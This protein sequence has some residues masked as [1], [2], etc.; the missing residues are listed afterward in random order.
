MS[1]D[2]SESYT[3]YPKSS[4]A[5]RRSA[6]LSTSAPLQAIESGKTSDEA[7]ALRVAGKRKRLV[8]TQED[9]LSLPPL[10]RDDSTTPSTPKRKRVSVNLLP[11]TPTPAAIGEMLTQHPSSDIHQSSP[12]PF[13]RLID[14]L[15][16]NAPLISP[17][18]SRVFM[19][20]P[21]DQASP[22]KTPTQPKTTTKNILDEAC[23][24]LIDVDE[25]LKPVIE[26]H[27]CRVFSP[28]GLA[29][30]IDPFRSLAS[31]I[32]SQQVRILH[33]SCTLPSF[34]QTTAPVA[35]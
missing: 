32:I 23:S 19:N 33:V 13:N 17:E 22:S 10:P 16:T 9:S 31:G 35:S 6:R 28:E 1:D 24:H 30:E 26:K 27:Y 8:E 14:P 15:R 25:R 34:S 11:I 3:T 4:M 12:P 29:E 2:Q 18:T 7:P 20:K 5:S 21:A